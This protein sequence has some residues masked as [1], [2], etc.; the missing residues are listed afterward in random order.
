[1]DNKQI[2]DIRSLSLPQQNYVEAIAEL[3]GQHGHAHTT[4]IARRLKVKKPSVTEAVNR[5]VDMGIARRSEQE[6]LLTE[7]GNAIAND[8]AHRHTT[9]R[10][11][12]INVLG[13]DPD[14]AD[15]AACEIEH[16]VNPDFVNRIAIL[17]K[18]MQKT[19]SESCKQKWKEI[20]TNPDS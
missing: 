10:S 19:I 7:N 8:L 17:E 6:V 11:F 12:M 13:M 15:A 20:I 18:F 14:K 3:T 5:L 9:L 16:S 4:E 1:M 2:D